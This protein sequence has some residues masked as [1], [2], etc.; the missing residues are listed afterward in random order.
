MDLVGGLMVAG[1]AFYVFRETDSR[2]RVTP[3]IRIGCYYAA[4]AMM[5]LMPANVLGFWG[6]FLLW[7]A[8][9]LGITAGAYFG[10][11]PGI[12]HKTDG[13]LPWS[14]RFVLAPMLIGQYMSLVYYRRSCRAWDEVVPAVLIGRTLT[15]AEAAEA[16]KQGVTAVL[17]LTAEFSEAAAFRNTTY[18]NL[19]ILD[20]TTPTQ[21]QLNEAAAFIA[22]EAL[23][24]TV[25]V[26]CKIGYSRSAA[27][28]GAYLLASGQTATVDDAVEMICEV[29]PS[30]IIRPEVVEA[31]CAFANC[32]PISN[33]HREAHVVVE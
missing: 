28:V 25:Y 10:L 13:R 4:G 17:D 15:E 3:N 22:E 7:P 5:V 19:P 23:R 18:R 27:V 2:R 32:E 24:G 29:R 14:T 9:A 1:F 26:H 33:L 31:L 8:A 30:I 21:E 12:F 16:I 6:T 20:L 11:G